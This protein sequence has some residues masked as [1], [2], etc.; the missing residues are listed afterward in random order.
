[1]LLF[2]LSFQ[3]SAEPFFHPDWQALDRNLNTIELNL[4]QLKTENNSL[5]IKLMNVSEMLQEQTKYSANQQIQYQIL[6]NN[7]QKLE[8]TT[9]LW[10]I[11]CCSFMTTTIGLV[12]VLIITRS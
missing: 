12:T 3:L 9:N 7:Y 10:K 11:G 4:T 2:I 5:Q 6:E 1:M 8:R